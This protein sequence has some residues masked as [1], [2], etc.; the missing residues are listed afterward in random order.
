MSAT[1]G[2]RDDVHVRLGTRLKA[3]APADGDIDLEVTLDV[4]R[5]HVARVVQDGDGLG[6]PIG[7][8]EPDHIGDCLAGRQEL[9]NSEM[10][11]WCR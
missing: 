9:A 4:G 7:P 10:P 11:P 2:C 1:F 5:F 6:E 8:S 3:L